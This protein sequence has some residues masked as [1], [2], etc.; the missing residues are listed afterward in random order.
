MS[1]EKNKNTFRVAALLLVACLISSVM[2]S[3]TFAKYTSEYA[4]QDTALVARWDLTMTDGETEFSVAP[5][6]AT[7]DL[8]SHLYD[9]NILSTAGTE[10]II[11]PGVSG[12]F[13]LSL[14]NNSDVAAEIKFDISK[15]GAEIPMQF[16]ITDN[17]DFDFDDEDY[18]D[19]ILDDIGELTDALN[20]ALSDEIFDESYQNGLIELAASDDE[21]NSKSTIKV[22]WRWPFGTSD[23][24][25]DETNV[26]D[27]TL[28]TD[29]A[30]AAA[31]PDGQ[32]TS[33]TLNIAITATQVEPD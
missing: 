8:F 14:T 5:N 20:G 6:V 32:R 27:T 26:A 11:A 25:N 2:L 18:Q 10:K 16:A 12:D 9:T 19:L 7:L 23:L 29:S 22:H 21:S 1:K 15:T 17:E 31:P 24:V 4:G 28:G 3:G 13:V 30:A 33:Y